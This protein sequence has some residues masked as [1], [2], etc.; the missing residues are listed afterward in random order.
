MKLEEE[1]SFG[2][3]FVLFSV[4]LMAVFIWLVIDETYISRPW[5][6]YQKRFYN[7][8]KE[9]LTDKIGEQQEDFTKTDKYGE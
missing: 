3:I 8:E 2:P 1:K 5:K 7:L 4:I 6:G 9:F